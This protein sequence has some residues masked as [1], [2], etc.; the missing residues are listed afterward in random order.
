[1]KNQKIIVGNWKMNP[2]STEEAVTIFKGI[3]K[4]LAKVS[5]K[6]VKAIICPSYVHIGL[7]KAKSKGLAFIVAQNTFTVSKGAYTGEVSPAMLKD[8]GVSHII[9]GHSERRKMGETDDEINKKVLLTLKSE[10]VPII[11][12]GETTRDEEGNYLNLIK[13]QVLQ[14]LKGVAKAQLSSLIIAYEPVWAIGSTTAMNAHDVHQMMIFIKKVLVD[15]YKTKTI[16]NTPVLYG[17]AVDPTNAHG[18]LTE[19]EADGLLI[20]RQSLEAQSFSEIIGFANA[21]K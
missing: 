21:L 5:S 4:G 6:K 17:G 14:A 10:L 13:D 3:E 19:G 12:V 18:I 11:C 15:Q 7:L 9:I 16:G 2:E 1:M 20:G 8:L